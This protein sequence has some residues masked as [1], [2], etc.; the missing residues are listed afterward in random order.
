MVNQRKYPRVP[1]HA[2][3]SFSDRSK[4]SGMMMD[5][6]REGALVTLDNNSLKPINA[7][8]SFMV[9]LADQSTI[10]IIGKV[11][12]HTLHDSKRAMGIAFLGLNPEDQKDWADFIEANKESTDIIPIR[13]LDT[14]KPED[15]A[16]PS[17]TLRFR[18]SDRLGVFL[19]K[20][21]DELI[22][23]TTKK[24]YTSGQLINLK[25]AHP[26]KTDFLSILVSV[27]RWGPHPSNDGKNGLYCKVE[28]PDSELQ[29]RIKAFA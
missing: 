21:I 25:I 22:Y 24:P 15:E 16:I 10:K 3:V 20:S 6:S 19:E 14:V 11:V 7:F 18:S 2:K 17:Y 8:V 9:D 27:V 12:R 5:A 23:F 26:E 1:T 4:A 29:N 28:G 13:A